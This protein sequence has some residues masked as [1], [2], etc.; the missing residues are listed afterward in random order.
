M[1]VYYF[2]HPWASDTEAYWLA[3]SRIVRGE[4]LYPHWSAPNLPDVYRY[5]P[6]FAWLWAPL[7]FGPKAL[8]SVVWFLGLVAATGYVAKGSGLLGIV[9]VPPLLGAAWIGNVHPLLVAALV[10]GIRHDRAAAA[11][12]VVASVKGFPILLA[13]HFVG[14]REWTKVVTAGLVAAALLAPLALYDLSA[15]VV[16]PARTPSLFSYAPL[17]WAATAFGAALLTVRFASTRYGWALAATCVL[18]ALP[19]MSFYD[20]GYLAVGLS[21]DPRDGTSVHPENLS[22]HRDR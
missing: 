20:L 21:L 14:R 3:G 9:I 1:A 12:G 17:L 19:R 6:W 8:V 10:A 5:A 2:L 4:A 11:I 7:T 15:Y 16:D 22:V 13:L 18:L